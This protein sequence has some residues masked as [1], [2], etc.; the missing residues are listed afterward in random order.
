MSRV[1][2]IPRYH[3][4]TS[5][6]LSA[7]LSK[8]PDVIPCSVR[9]KFRVSDENAL[10]DGLF[11]FE[12]DL[13]LDDVSDSDEEGIENA[14]D[15][16]FAYAFGMKKNQ[17]LV[18]ALGQILGDF[19]VSN[20]GRFKRVFSDD[21][22]LF[23]IITNLYSGVWDV[24]APRVENWVVAS[25]VAQT[26]SF[27]GCATD[28]VNT[29]GTSIMQG[30]E[31]IFE[32]VK[33]IDP[34]L[35]S[36]M[37]AAEAFRMSFDHVLIRKYLDAFINDQEESDWK[38]CQIKGT[39]L[40]DCFPYLEFYRIHSFCFIYF[41]NELY[42]LDNGLICE[43][44]EILKTPAGYLA[45]CAGY[46]PAEPGAAEGAVE[47]F[48]KLHQYLVDTLVKR[49]E[50]RGGYETFAKQM[51]ESYAVILAD[52]G[53]T[54][55]GH[56]G[57]DQAREI[58]AS[59]TE[60]CSGETPYFEILRTIEP[61]LAVDIGTYWNALPASDADS[62][63][64]D[65][66]LQRVMNAERN[67]DEVLW[68]KFM[69]YCRS[70]ITAHLIFKNQDAYSLHQWVHP[71]EIADPRDL[72]WVTNC[73]S[74]H[75]HYPP[76]DQ[77]GNVYLT[78]VLNWD[79]KMESW[80]FAAQD[81]THVFSDLAQYSTI[82]NISMIPRG[83]SNEILYALSRGPLL[84][85]VFTPEV[86]RQAMR[87]GHLPGDRILYLAA[88]RENTKY[89][90]KVR[91][92]AS[93]DDVLREA[94]SELDMNAQHIATS[95]HGVAMRMGRAGFEKR[96][97][98]MKAQVQGGQVYISLDVS[99]WSPNMNRAHQMEF[100]DM[101]MEFF[102]IPNE[103]RASRWFQEIKVVHSRR[104]F[105]SIWDMLDGSV[106]GFFGCADSIMHNLLAQFAKVQAEEQGILERGSK[107][108]FMTLID[109]LAIK[110]LSGNVNVERVLRS[111]EQTYLALGF[112][113]DLVKTLISTDHFHFLNRLY[114]PEGEV[115]TAAKI[116]AKSGREFETKLPPVWPLI[117]SCLTSVLGAVDRGASVIKGY[118]WALTHAI[119]TAHSFNRNI[120]SD[121]WS[122]TH[123]GAWLP[124][125]LGGWGLP[126]VVSWITQEGIDALT[127]GV[128][129]IYRLIRITDLEET[130]EALQRLILSALN[131][132]IRKRRIDIAVANPYGV[133]VEGVVDVVGEIQMLLEKATS[134]IVR[135]TDFVQL[136]EYSAGAQGLEVLESLA[137]SCN[138]P[139]AIWSA[140]GECLPDA[141]W[142]AI[143]SRATKN[144]ALLFRLPKSVVKGAKRNL[145]VKNER[146][147]RQYLDIPQTP[148]ER[149]MLMRSA[150]SAI[151]QLRNEQLTLD[152]VCAYDLETTPSLEVVARCNET[153]SIRLHIPETTGQ[154]MYS[155]KRQW[156]L[157]RTFRSTGAII[158]HTET[159]KVFDPVVKT[160]G[161]FGIVKAA[162][163]AIGGDA[164]PLEM[165]YNSIW[166]GR[167][168]YM[169]IGTPR[170]TAS[171]PRRICS[172]TSNMTHSVMA[173]PNFAGSVRVDAHRAISAFENAHKTFDWLSVIT[174]LRAIGV[175]D[176]ETSNQA[177][178]ATGHRTSRTIEFNL[179]GHTG[180]RPDDGK[181]FEIITELFDEKVKACRGI[182]SEDFKKHLLRISGAVLNR[183][184][185][186]SV[187]DREAIV[188][189][190]GYT[191]AFTVVSYNP[192]DVLRKR[193]INLTAI[194]NVEA[195]PYS[196]LATVGKAT[197]NLP[198]SSK[199]TS[200]VINP[201]SNFFSRMKTRVARTSMSEGERNLAQCLLSFAKLYEV[202]R[203]ESSKRRAYFNMWREV[204]AIS[205]WAD[206]LTRWG[207]A[208]F[209][210]LLANRD[211]RYADDV[212]KQVKIDVN[213]PEPSGF[214]GNAVERMNAYRKYGQGYLVDARKVEKELNAYTG[215][216][217]DKPRSMAVFHK[218]MINSITMCTFA[219]AV[220]QGENAFSV[221]I[222]LGD[223]IENYLNSLRERINDRKVSLKSNSRAYVWLQNIGIFTKEVLEEINR[224]FSDMWHG[225]KEL[226]KGAEWSTKSAM[227]WLI[228]DFV[229]T[230][231]LTRHT[232]DRMPEAEAR[233]EGE[234]FEAVDV[235]RMVAVLPQGAALSLPLIED[236]PSCMTD[237]QS[238]FADVA[239]LVNFKSSHWFAFCKANA[240]SPTK[241]IDKELLLDYLYYRQELDESKNAPKADVISEVPRSSR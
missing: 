51:K 58:A 222:T 49:K 101:L 183:Y 61:H 239:A 26:L 144:Q 149:G 225:R 206:I 4:Q 91:E 25:K 142:S 119:H 194:S 209:V 113:T 3:R 154:E 231:A 153:G 32:A 197:F 131:Q 205:S 48:V 227:E 90:E 1:F 38:R 218:R 228:S 52:I 188:N 219:T 135:S 56:A 176:S 150:S 118:E 120:Y 86:V 174:A 111:F 35:A 67:S 211:Y 182:L 157:R 92:T 195:N 216:G 53:S 20:S 128:A 43:L 156:T 121:G 140:F 172:A 46:R 70:V 169:R 124:R 134:K 230:E 75:L 127:D 22:A 234:E 23:R 66:R 59:A 17:K 87:D 232:I 196:T 203:T 41:K 115:V 193:N 155:G 2:S 170:V 47:A 152:G 112:E 221:L 65:K 80:H 84:S 30:G 103:M 24:K 177:E 175:V 37:S 179:S 45:Y 100:I 129:R 163:V 104:G 223:Q 21:V 19:V 141:V 28:R 171:D 229:I 122:L 215:D 39:H 77:W 29:V 139:A 167:P 185:G 191:P 236:D 158:D 198:V 164:L 192:H 220:L 159:V 133:S 13:D 217:P 31:S 107:V 105:H 76:A 125:A 189:A 71:E 64:M 15:D 132:K 109:D 161:K 14:R 212:Y 186:A 72:R 94:L 213:H 7:L 73:V 60:L 143:M 18:D 102:K 178:E 237:A 83:E 96:M 108:D 238:E 224:C 123:F 162:V 78:G 63:L 187:A 138:Y 160:I 54:A 36:L 200:D 81:V 207:N 136:M 79:M 202:A 226:A 180:F 184:T 126:G 117:D 214:K 9:R 74:G 55:A 199:G 165:A 110:I 181:P 208:H 33:R 204:Q 42:V 27:I 201:S 16:D 82:R 44:H 68:A 6:S 240:R 12:R 97:E 116:F 10:D 137:G 93:G 85:N 34:R 50:I 235:S 241:D 173:F 69:R 166:F 233:P 98:R 40:N 146:A 89:G 145:R 5:A 114:S 147:L 8:Y 106:Q 11:M 168:D 88:K 99:A 190:F 151:A 210:A 57:L 95:M 148:D 130:K 62:L